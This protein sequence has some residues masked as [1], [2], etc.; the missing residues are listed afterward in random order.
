MVE[1]VTK[2]VVEVSYVPTRE[3]ILNEIFERIQQGFAWHHYMTY[4]G[5]ENFLKA[6]ALIELLE[7]FD[8]GSTGGF[9]KRQPEASSGASGLCSRLDWL[10]KKH[11][12]YES[13]TL[14][15]TRQQLAE[16]ADKIN[17]YTA[18]EE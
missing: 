16:L 13:D 12:S 17:V 5:I 4:R 7:V 9:D 8:C 15:F 6:T 10:T 1:T 14:K 2:V 3:V 11:N 18:E